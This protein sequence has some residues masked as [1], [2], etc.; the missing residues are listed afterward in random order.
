MKN[1][2]KLINSYKNCFRATRKSREIMQNTIQKRSGLCLSSIYPIFF[3]LN[4]DNENSPRSDYYKLFK[5]DVCLEKCLL[6]LKNEQRL[7]NK[8]KML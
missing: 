6:K 3:L 5:N 7:Y 1:K 8:I 4:N 2:L